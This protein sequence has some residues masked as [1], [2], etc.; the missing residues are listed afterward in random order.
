MSGGTLSEIPRDDRLDVFI[1]LLKEKFLRCD[2]LTKRLPK[3]VGNIIRFVGKSGGN[4]YSL[5]I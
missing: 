2:G 3:T 1:F 5:N 4:C